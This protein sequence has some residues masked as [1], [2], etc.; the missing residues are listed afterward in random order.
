MEKWTEEE[1]ET[2]VAVVKSDLKHNT[3]DRRE[4]ID[5]NIR[6]ELYMSVIRELF[7]ERGFIHMEPA[8]DATG[9]KSCYI[10]GYVNDVWDYLMEAYDLVHDKKYTYNLEKP[11]KFKNG[12]NG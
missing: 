2:R 8:D 1:I 11:K 12:N 10:K 7:S 3:I 5:K 4:V 6:R 9:R